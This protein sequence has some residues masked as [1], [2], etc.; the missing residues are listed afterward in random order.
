MIRVKCKDNKEI[1]L[2]KQSKIFTEGFPATVSLNNI[3]SLATSNDLLPQEYYGT[4]SAY[5]Y[6]KYVDCV[7]IDANKLLRETG[8]KRYQI[9]DKIAILIDVIYSN[10]NSRWDII[11]I[12][13]YNGNKIFTTSS[14]YAGGKC[15][16]IR[17]EKLIYS[18]YIAD[19]RYSDYPRILLCTES[20][21]ITKIENIQILIMKQSTDGNNFTLFSY[22]PFRNLRYDE[23]DYHYTYL[24]EF[25]LELRG[26]T[27]ISEPISDS[28]PDVNGDYDNTSDE[29]MIDDINNINLSSALQ[30]NFVKCYAMSAENLIKLSDFLWSDNFIDVIK[31]LQNDPM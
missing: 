31:K 3:E 23:T 6:N 10:E 1:R 14:T 22:M 24:R 27:T 18:N 26:A 12:F 2:V 19:V 13:E 17:Q 7:G 4:G 16:S 25:F 8:G 28:I 9:N 5:L 15:Q 30:S 20:D 21:D 29:V 11:I